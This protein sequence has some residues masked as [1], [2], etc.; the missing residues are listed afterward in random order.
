MFLPSISLGL[1][2][3]VKSQNEGFTSIGNNNNEGSTA[4]GNNSSNIFNISNRDIESNILS[5]SPTNGSN[6]INIAFG[7]DTHDLYIWNGS[8]W[9]KYLNDA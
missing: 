3:S 7:T 2:S 9:N 1:V 5:S 4:G 6:F 8:V